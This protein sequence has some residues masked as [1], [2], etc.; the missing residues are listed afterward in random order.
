MAAYQQTLNCKFL[1]AFT[2][3]FKKMYVHVYVLIW[4]YVYLYA[5]SILIGL[6]IRYKAISLCVS[7]RNSHS[8]NTQAF[9][10]N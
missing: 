10:L 1:S 5:H 9:H 3:V 8:R 6:K 4:S 2:A 7:H